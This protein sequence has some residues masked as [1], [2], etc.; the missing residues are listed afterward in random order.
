MTIRTLAALAVATLLA[1][2]A[3]PVAK[4]D[5]PAGRADCVPGLTSYPSMTELSS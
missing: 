1:A 3:V 5:P 4:A 2:V